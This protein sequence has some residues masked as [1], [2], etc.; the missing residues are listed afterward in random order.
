MRV[1]LDI[2]LRH[3]PCAILSLDLLD[4]LRHHQVDINIPKKKI[5]KDGNVLEGYLPKTSTEEQ[6]NEIVQDLNDGIGCRIDG[7]FSIDKV[8]GN[9]HISFHNYMQ[10]YQ[11]LLYS[12]HDVFMKLNLS[13]EIK[14]LIFGTERNDTLKY[15]I[16]NLLKE[17]ELDDQ[18]LNNFV[19]HREV[20]EDHFIAA[21]WIEIIPYTFIDN[22]DGFTYF[23]YLHSFNRKIK[24]I[25]PNEI[26]QTVPLLEFHYKFSTLTAKYEIEVKKT[27]HFLMEVIATVGAL[28]AFFEIF[29][30]YSNAILEA[31]L[32][33][34]N[35]AEV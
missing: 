24:P 21:H 22:R 17:M 1:R 8:S 28:F 25:E 29:N 31:I 23:S 26:D 16:E 20:V 19:D 33:K 32:G 27:F 5:D 3:A 15:K 11:K 10:H 14:E 35:Q 34:Q 6:F 18:I 2:V 4:D 7:Q 13:F 9:F 12:N 30:N